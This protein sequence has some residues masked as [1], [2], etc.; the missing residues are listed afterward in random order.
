MVYAT[1]N[2]H[3]SGIFSLMTAP[4]SALMAVLLANVPLRL[5]AP[6]LALSGKEVLTIFVIV[7][8]CAAVAGEHTYWTYSELYVYPLSGRHDAFWKDHTLKYVPNWMI[9]KDLATVLDIEG[10]GRDIGYVIGKIPRLILPWVGWFGVYG[11]MMLAYLCI[12]LLM[13][14]AWCDRE[15][16]TFP[17]IQLPVAMSENGGAGGIWRSPHLWVAFGV[18]FSIQMLNGF[19][20][21]FPNVPEVP[22]KSWVFLNELFKEPPWN[23]IGDF[24]LSL[25]PYMSVLGLLM[26]TDLTF[27]IVF[28]FLLKK[29]ALV[30][31]AGSGIYAGPWQTSGAP[32]FPEQTWGGVI[33][34][35]L[36]IV[37]TSQ[38]YLKRVGRDIRSGL[39]GEDG[40]PS[41]RWALF[42]LVASFA[43]ITAYGMAAEMPV[44][45]V[46]PYFAMFLVFSVVLTRIRAQLGPPT[47]EFAWWGVQRLG[48][49]F[50]GNRWITVP[51]AARF[52]MF[53]RPMNLIYRNHPMPYQ[54]EALKIAR[55]H[56]LN[57]KGV[58]AISLATIVI[59][60]FLAY[61][62][63][64]VASYRT[65]RLGWAGAAN[66]L[67]NMLDKRT[68]PDTVAMA[69]VIFGV[70]VV[71]LL[72][73]VRFRFPGFPLHPA[74]YVL[75][76]TYGVEY[77]WFGL[78][79]ALLV[80]LFVNRY[81]GLRGYE[82]LRN[83]AF[84]ILIGEYAAET[85]W[86]TM[87]L[88]TGQ[89]TYTISFN[90]RSL[91]MQ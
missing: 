50:V 72:D 79:I 87:A 5:L 32:Y 83:I 54:L 2:A 17:L 4:L 45:Y 48:D 14:G 28:F 66:D 56:R 91:G 75:S 30:V 47:H 38:A 24:R 64:T 46:V 35:F 11:A 13:R 1:T 58:V 33:G 65:G 19:N 18:M 77:Y 85:I 84:G 31:L 80:K 74:G 57:V 34:M 44:L 12:N 55:D 71:M 43:I 21:L 67:R 59:G 70:A 25:Y 88:V 89:S 27:S 10:G 52:T 15:R 6:K 51:Q 90:D 73:T 3:Q 63:L 20:Y 78:L 82:K 40:G 69:A 60:F 81:Y 8:T 23:G 41:H 42:G 7:S 39:P 68:G 76:L 16:L 36:G 29:V 37:W 62:F 9:V 22:V 49:I 61:F 86:M 26:P 53:F